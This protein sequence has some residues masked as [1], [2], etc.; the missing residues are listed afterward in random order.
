MAK[1]RYPV[2]ERIRD[3]RAG[4]ERRMM[5]TLRMRLAWEEPLKKGGVFAPRCGLLWTDNYG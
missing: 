1:V 5:I 2:M 3:K 4:E